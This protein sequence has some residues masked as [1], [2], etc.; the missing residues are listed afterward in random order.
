M[1]DTIGTGPA[2]RRAGVSR[3][4][5]SSRPLPRRHRLTGQVPEGIP[6]RTSGAPPAAA[7]AP[8]SSAPTIDGRLDDAA[9]MGGQ[10]LS[11]LVQREPYEGTPVSQRTEVRIVYDE[12]ALYVGAWLFDDEPSAL[13]FGQTLRDA[14]LNEADAFVIVFDTYQDGQN[15]FVFGTTPAGI[16]YDGQFTNEGQGGGGRG[17][18]GIGRQQSGSGGGFNLNWDGSWEVATSTERGGLVRRD[19]HPLHHACVTARSVRADLG[20]QLRAEHPP[21][22]RAFRLGAVAPGSSTIYR[23]S[24]A[25]SLA[26]P[27]SGEQRI[28]TV[29]PYVLSD[30][31]KDYQVTS[32]EVELRRQ[33]RGRRQIRLH[34]RA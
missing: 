19:A 32:P 34:V 3:C 9:W 28:A 1:P 26:P 10:A 30:A 23:V 4:S 8:V 21:E 24:L 6:A 11:G 5:S 7:A 2:R 17:G 13:V 25:G 14:S 16:E 31:F 29:S 12:D 27:G 33:D 18:G 22:Q 15:G 20:T